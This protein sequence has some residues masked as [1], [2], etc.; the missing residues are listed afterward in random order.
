MV[1]EQRGKGDEGSNG[2]GNE[3]NSRVVRVGRWFNWR[4]REGIY[5]EDFRRGLVVVPRDKEDK[6]CDP[7]AQ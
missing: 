5:E 1:Q 6:P 4:S 3:R 7:R 2:A